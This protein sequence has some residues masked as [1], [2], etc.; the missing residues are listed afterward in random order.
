MSYNYRRHFKPELV[1]DLIRQVSFCEKP[2]EPKQFWNMD[3]FYSPSEQ[4][5][6]VFLSGEHGCTDSDADFAIWGISGKG[7]AEEVAD[8]ILEE[9]VEEF[10]IPEG[11]FYCRPITWTSPSPI[12][13]L[14]IHDVQLLL[15]EEQVS[16]LAD[17]EKVQQVKVE[18][19]P[20]SERKEFWASFPPDQR[21]E[22]LAILNRYVKG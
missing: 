2:D 18:I 19:K 3:I 16:L 10:D 20:F 17:L 11:G 21:E 1:T 4:E 15:I 8:K 14:I 6:Y 5:F 12:E 22:V 7:T 13:T 9:F